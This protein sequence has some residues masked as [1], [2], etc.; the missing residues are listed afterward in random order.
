MIKDLKEEHKATLQAV[1]E[2]L[3]SLKT[4]LVEKDTILLKMQEEMSVKEA[5]KI[6]KLEKEE[7][8]YCELSEAMSQQNLSITELKQS[9]TCKN[10]QMKVIEDYNGTLADENI[11]VKNENRI[12]KHQIEQNGNKSIL[13][14]DGRI[15]ML[16]K[17][18]ND[19]KTFVCSELE[20]IKQQLHIKNDVPKSVNNPPLSTNQNKNLNLQANKD[21]LPE[22][23]ATEK[24][25]VVD[26]KA[27]SKEV[28]AA[29]QQTDEHLQTN[30]TASDH[31]TEETEHLVNS[32]N[33][34][35]TQQQHNTT[36]KINTL[37]S[38]STS[39]ENNIFGG[40]AN[41]HTLNSTTNDHSSIGDGV[42]E[43]GDHRSDSKRTLIFTTSISKGINSRTFNECYN[44]RRAQFTRFPGA[45]A[46]HMS[47]YVT[48]RIRDERPE[49]VIIHAGGN[50]LPVNNNER[51][52]SLWTVA[53]FITDAAMVA[54]N[55]G[56]RNI[57]IGGV[58]TRKG[59]FLKKRCDALN[60]ILISLCKR[61]GFIYIDNSGI[62][63]EHLYVDGVHL[64]HK[65]TVRLADNYL[66]A[67][68]K[69][70]LNST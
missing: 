11:R 55:H 44:P 49:T 32:Q 54:R 28:E 66:D 65:G 69:L 17:D 33:N 27:A 58:T 30:T 18:Q 23:S 15:S 5:E 35:T 67:L 6:T 2:E 63:D 61:K 43:R 8:K 10:H 34:N 39:A 16:Q 53:N 26:G 13:D 59:G 42:E 62:G 47:E 46:K 3:S 36:Q 45:R 50:D 9:L 56:A 52:V 14:S 4:K 24:E 41:E 37:L 7:R 70:P 21:S 22:S 48:P 57:L 38:S 68:K 51:Y 19:F 12:L 25:L 60:G 40:D 29:M 20:T 31:S 1:D 64:N